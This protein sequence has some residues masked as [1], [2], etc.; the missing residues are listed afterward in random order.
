ME[1]PSG[2]IVAGGVVM[3]R[4]MVPAAAGT[5]MVVDA[6]GIVVFLLSDGSSCTRSVKKIR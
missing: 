5:D 6:A 3:W 1:V 4:V 2:V